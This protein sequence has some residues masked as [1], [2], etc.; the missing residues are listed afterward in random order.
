MAGAEGIEPPARGFGVDVE[1]ELQTIYQFR[2]FYVTEAMVGR[3][4]IAPQY[5]KNRNIYRKRVRFIP[6]ANAQAR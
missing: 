5:T 4:P 1:E 3:T 2:K 6:D